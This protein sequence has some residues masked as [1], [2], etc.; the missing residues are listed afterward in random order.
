MWKQHQDAARKEQLDFESP[1]SFYISA[2][3]PSSAHFKCLQFSFAIKAQ[4]PCARSHQ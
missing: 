4:N 1:E 2:N 3:F